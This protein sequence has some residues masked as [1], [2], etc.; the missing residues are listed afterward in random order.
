MG[1]VPFQEAKWP[2]SAKLG[3]D[4][5]DV[6]EEAGGAGRTDAVEVL[7]AAAGGKRHQRSQ[8]NVGGL[9]RWSMRRGSLISSPASRRRVRPAISRGRTVASRA[10]AWAADRTFVAPPGVIPSSSRCSWQTVRV[11]AWPRDRRR[12]ARSRRAASA[13]QQRT[14][15][16]PGMRD[17]TTATECASVAS[18]LRPW[19]VANTRMRA[20]SLG[21]T[22][23][24]CSPS[25]KSRFARC[26]P[27]PWHPSIAHSGPAS[28]W[29]PPASPHTRRRRCHTGPGQQR[30]HHRP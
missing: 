25:A 12:S 3:V 10:R 7:E 14:G 8:L 22:S 16:S 19:P 30:P 11:R 6:T 15:R 29:P 28:A 21:G 23:T 1:A 27:M 20:D 18:V 13:R 4:V 17:A 9:L 26:L 5:T 24:T 2:R